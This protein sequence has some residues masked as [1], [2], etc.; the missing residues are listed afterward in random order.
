MA[1][2]FLTKSKLSQKLP[3]VD[4][5]LSPVGQ[6]LIPGAHSAIRRFRKQVT[7]LLMD[8]DQWFSKRDL[9]TPLLSGLLKVQHYFHNNIK[10]S[11]AYL[12]FGSLPTPTPH[13]YSFQTI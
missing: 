12:L 4:F 9:D 6:N 7:G 3:S 5:S 2:Y 1:L 8:F 13:E 10:M 11:F